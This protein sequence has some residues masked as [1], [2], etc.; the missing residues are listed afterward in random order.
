MAKLSAAL[1][2]VPKTQEHKD[3]IAATQR[4]RQMAASILRAV[5]DV[6]S[7]QQASLPASAAGY[8]RVASFAAFH[9]MCLY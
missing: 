9:L 7:Q 3:A 5:E 8:A 1:T 2:G 6:H 4:R